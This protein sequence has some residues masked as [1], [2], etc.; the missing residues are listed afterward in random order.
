MKAVTQPSVI[1]LSTSEPAIDPD[2]ARRVGQEVLENRLDP[3]TWATALSAS[4]G[5]RQDALAV[6]AR[7]RIQQLGTRRRRTHARVESFDFRRVN[8][9]FGVK[10]VQDLL[11]RTNPGKQLNLVKPRLSLISLM[12]LG[13]GAAGCVGSLGR[14]LGGALP[15]R[16]AAMVP[17]A[18]IVCGIAAVVT[19]V[20]LRFILPKRW[21]MVG[22]NS[23][24]LAI[25]SMACF[26]SLLFGVKLI[27]HAPP[28]ELRKTAARPLAVSNAPVLV[29]PKAVPTRMTVS[30]ENS[31]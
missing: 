14:L 29:K 3:A 28:L 13:I 16:F 20:S 18:A 11:Q 23:G 6:Y 27:S 17:I 1:K 7:L 2:V 19:V 5:K 30:N 12:T 24:M 26:A 8:H 15:E 31:R 10:T 4:G 9:C 22:W 21:I 25:C